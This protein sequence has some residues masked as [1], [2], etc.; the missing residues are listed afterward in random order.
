MSSGEDPCTWAYFDLPV[1]DKPVMGRGQPYYIN[2]H[3]VQQLRAHV[4]KD[5]RTDPPSV[6]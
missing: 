3:G 5:K 1:E 6:V 4:Q 2:A